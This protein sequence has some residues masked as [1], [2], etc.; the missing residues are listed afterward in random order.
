MSRVRLLAAGI[1]VLALAV[2]AGATAPAY[3]LPYCHNLEGKRCA[4]GSS[5]QCITLSG[6][7]SRCVCIGVAGGG[8]WECYS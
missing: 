4:A 3:A 1:G 7:T 6:T 5:T 2:W 8:A